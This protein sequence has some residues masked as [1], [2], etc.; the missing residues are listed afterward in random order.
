MICDHERWVGTEHEGAC[1]PVCTTTTTTTKALCDDFECPENYSPKTNATGTTADRATCCIRDGVCN[2]QP[3]GSQCSTG[4]IEKSLIPNPSFEEKTGCNTASAQLTKAVGWGQAT[5]ATSDYWVGQPSCPGAGSGASGWYVPKAF[6]GDAVVGAARG[7]TGNWHEYV[8]TC[9]NSPL[10]PG[11]NYTFNLAI[12]VGAWSSGW[13]GTTD[14]K[15]VLLCIPDCNFPIN[16]RNCQTDNFEVLAE[17]A[18][19]GLITKG[20]GWKA[21]TFAWTQKTE[22]KA[23]MFGQACDSMIQAGMAYGNYVVYDS[24]NLQPGDAGKCDENGECVMR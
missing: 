11:M 23:I 21:L 2:G 5:I 1:N 7:K 19:G 10:Q 14:G 17:A 24:L 9:L 13:T 16:V 22:C 8:G 12:A 6:D 15:S 4:D 20:G 18:P 3:V